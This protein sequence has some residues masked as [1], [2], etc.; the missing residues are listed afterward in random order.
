MGISSAIDKYH[1]CMYRIFKDLT[2]IVVFLYDLPDVSTTW[3][4][5]LAHLHI[6]FESLQIFVV[7][8]SE[9]TC[10]F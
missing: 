7:S 4:D 6:F 9:L 10:H 2:F 5:H 3:R 1:A 8:L